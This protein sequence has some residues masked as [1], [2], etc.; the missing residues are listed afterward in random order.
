M[1]SLPPKNLE[2]LWTK[3]AQL[4]PPFPNPKASVTTWKYSE[5]EPLLMQSGDIVEAEEAER[6][7][8]ML[9][10]KDMGESLDC[11]FPCRGAN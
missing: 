7:V 1:A 8:L 11:I 10:N 6:R 5:C 9:V 2:P 4:V 3:M